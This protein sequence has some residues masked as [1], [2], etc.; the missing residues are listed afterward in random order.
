MTPEE[1]QIKMQEIKN[2]Y[3]GDEE[4]FHGKADDLLCEVLIELGYKNGVEIFK[5]SDKWYA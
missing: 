5:N 4:A 2:N 3:G 1:F